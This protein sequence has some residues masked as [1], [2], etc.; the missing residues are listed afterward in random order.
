MEGPQGQVAGQERVRHIIDIEYVYGR[1]IVGYQTAT[2]GGC[3]QMLAQ[4]LHRLGLKERDMLLAGQEVTA[5]KLLKLFLIDLSR[6]R[7]L[8]DAARTD[9][10]KVIEQL[11][12]ILLQIVTIGQTAQLFARLVGQSHIIEIATI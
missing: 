3:T 11:D 1:G 5:D 6:S 2:H 12:S 4:A 8:D 10:V 7:G 9:I